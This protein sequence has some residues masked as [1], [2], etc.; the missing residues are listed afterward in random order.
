MGKTQGYISEDVKR[1]TLNNCREFITQQ[2]N[3]NTYKKCQWLLEKAGFYFSNQSLIQF[4][5]PSPSNEFKSVS[6]NGEYL[7]ERSYDVAQLSESVN[8]KNK[9][10]NSEKGQIY[11]VVLKS[12][13]SSYG[14]LFFLDAPG[15]TGKTILINMLLATIR[16]HKTYQYLY[17]LLEALDRNL[18]AIRISKE[19]MSGMTVLL[20]EDFRR[21]LYVVP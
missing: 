13:D 16:M 18:K 8:G 9:T 19:L 6:V 4:G 2:I 10:L 17:H 7:K 14:Q 15:G 5:L 12:V 20:E 3:N 21:T 11:N 1:Q